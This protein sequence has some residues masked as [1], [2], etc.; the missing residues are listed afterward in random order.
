MAGQ[1]SF[2]ACCWRGA[3]A[4]LGTG[5]TGVGWREGAK[6]PVWCTHGSL[7][8]VHSPG[9]VCRQGVSTAEVTEAAVRP[10]QI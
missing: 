8:V 3:G 9:W 4:V 6:P 7:S 10:L 2:I 5:N 1:V